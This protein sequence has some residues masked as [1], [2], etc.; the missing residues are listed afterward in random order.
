[1]RERKVW[2][3]TT[4]L[5]ILGL[6]MTACAPAPATGGAASGQTQSAA[7]AAEGPKGTLTIGLTTDI[8]AIEVPYAP[9]RQAAN[10]SWTLYDGLVFPEADG[11]YSPALA[12]KWDVSDDGTTYTF[13]LRNNVTFHNGEPFNADAV[14]Y[15][16]Q[17]YS[18]PEV[19]YAN[20]W[21]FAKSVE[22]AMKN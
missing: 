20:E 2:L 4:L 10:A 15:S 21:S 18:Q 8:A 9:E 7:P 22:K 16:W 19:T 6:L 14:V 17:T 13:H 12:E 1:M 3:F 5:L 11:T